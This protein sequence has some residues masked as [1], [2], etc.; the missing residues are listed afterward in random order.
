MSRLTPRRTRRCLGDVADL[1]EGVEYLVEVSVALE[2]GDGC[3]RR[4]ER[5]V[6]LRE[7]PRGRLAPGTEPSLRVDRVGQSRAQCASN[8]VV[9]EMQCRS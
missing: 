6:A 1:S 3:S 9:E 8:R 2:R 7:S 4:L 5:T